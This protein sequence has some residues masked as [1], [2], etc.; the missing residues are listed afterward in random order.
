[1]PFV[2]LPIESSVVSESLPPEETFNIIA[3]EPD[4]QFEKQRRYDISLRV[5][6]REAMEQNA[7]RILGFSLI[8]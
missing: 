1:V 6:K 5:T 7:V 8:G 2:C 3:I 4:R